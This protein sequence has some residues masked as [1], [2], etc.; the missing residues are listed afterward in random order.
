[1]KLAEL[2]TTIFNDAGSPVELDGL[3]NDV[4]ALRRHKPQK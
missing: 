2:V 1:M 3:V 4:R